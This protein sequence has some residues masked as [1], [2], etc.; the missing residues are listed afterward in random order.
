MSKE[1]LD[2]IISSA[3]KLS[4]NDARDVIR[5]KKVTVDGAVVHDPAFKADPEMSVILLDG[6]AVTYKKYV[7]YMLNKPAGVLSASSDKTRRTVVDIIADDTLR[8]GL[9]PVGRLDRDT[10]GL[11]IVTDDGDYGHRVISPKSYIEKEYIAWLD[12]PVSDS[13]IAALKDGAV[14]ADGTQCRPAAVLPQSADRM[15]VSVT[16]TEGKYHEIKRM[17][18]T[19]GIGVVS[20]KRVRIGKLLLDTE[21]DTGKYREMT[22]EECELTLK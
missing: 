3:A 14:L 21:L 2:K 22:A 5:A 10:T 11:L 20:L 16:I 12:K 4:R 6:A 1:R 13:D 7:Y 9:F 15:T 8:R 17:L 18:G 19:V